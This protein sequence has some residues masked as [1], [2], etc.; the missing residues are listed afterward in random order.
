MSINHNQD[1]EKISEENKGLLKKL[2]REKI[3]KIGLIVFILGSISLVAYLW[4]QAHSEN[5]ELYQELSLSLAS[6]CVSVLLIDILLTN[7]LRKETHH[8]LTDICKSLYDDRDPMLSDFC[9][10]R[11]ENV[12]KNSLSNVTGQ[13]YTENVLMPIIHRFTRKVSFRTEFDYTVSINKGSDNFPK[14]THPIIRQE[15]SY[16]K[17]LREPELLNYKLVCLFTLGDPFKIQTAKDEIIF[18]REEIPFSFEELLQQADININDQSDIPA[19][20][21]KVFR[22]RMYISSKP[23]KDLSIEVLRKENKITGIKIYKLLSK[24]DWSH[25]TFEKCMC[26]KAKL[27]CTYPSPQKFFYWKFPEPIFAKEGLSTKFKF[28]FGEQYPVNLE[29]VHWMSY[30]S[31]TRHE[32]NMRANGNDVEEEHIVFDNRCLEFDSD[33]IH[34]PESG[35]YIHWQ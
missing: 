22:I 15:L 28:R 29:T 20:I 17:H 1:Y 34:F 5:Y 21:E 14:A 7:Y 4:F 3:S 32:Q 16:R 26:F 8:E 19:I 6:S 23:I 11:L 12:A 30:F 18:F 33:D 35:I 27:T 13:P 10:S 2:I 9:H 24:E 31:E 25:S